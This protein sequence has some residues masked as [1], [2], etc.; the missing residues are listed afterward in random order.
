MNIKIKGTLL[1]DFYIQKTVF[2]LDHSLPPSGA[3]ANERAVLWQCKADLW[4]FFQWILTFI[5][6][7]VV[8][9]NK[10]KKF[11]NFRMKF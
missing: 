5:F 11:Q 10:T 2:S 4:P 6:R 9:K 8:L 7:W 3:G 1:K